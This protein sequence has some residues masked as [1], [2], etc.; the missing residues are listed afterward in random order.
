MRIQTPDF[1][2]PVIQARLPDGRRVRINDHGVVEV[3]EPLTGHHYELTLPSLQ[4]AADQCSERDA[5]PQQPDFPYAGTFT[6]T[7]SHVHS[8]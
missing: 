6:I 3:H 4:F 8:D 1:M 2:L 5:D 7:A